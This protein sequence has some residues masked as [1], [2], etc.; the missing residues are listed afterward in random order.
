MNAWLKTTA[1]SVAL[2][3]GFMA[4]ATTTSQAGAQAAAPQLQRTRVSI[5]PC[6]PQ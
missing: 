5:G 1:A 2:T 3:V 4:A 6:A